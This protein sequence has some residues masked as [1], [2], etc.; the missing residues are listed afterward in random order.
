M[1]GYGAV[2]KDWRARPWQL[3]VA[4]SE[5]H[6]EHRLFDTQSKASILAFHYQS[7]NAISTWRFQIEW[8]LSFSIS[9][10]SP[11]FSYDDESKQDTTELPAGAY[12]LHI[13]CQGLRSASR[14][15]LTVT[16]YLVIWKRYHIELL[17]LEHTW[18][19]LHWL[20]LLFSIVGTWD[21][22]E[23]WASIKVS[24][25]LPPYYFK[26]HT[27]WWD[28]K[29][30]RWSNSPSVALLP[31]F[32]APCTGTWDIL[33]CPLTMGSLRRSWLLQFA[34]SEV[35]LQHCTF[36]R[37]FAN[38][39]LLRLL[40][41]KE[42]EQCHRVCHAWWRNECTE[43]RG[44]AKLYEWMRTLQNTLTY[45]YH[46][47]SSTPV[48]L[49]IVS[50]TVHRLQYAFDYLWMWVWTSRSKTIQNHLWDEVAFHP[51]LA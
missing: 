26:Q 1:S 19:D 10:L 6:Q 21:W 34:L 25:S 29:Q 32:L 38:I 39:F 42:P 5:L 35:I 23:H 17:C 31:F 15:K 46:L 24:Q 3:Q 7:I 43:T 2:L 44:M 20:L 50:K 51:C 45:L 33:R 30:R 22:F 12:C 14:W 4:S 48:W 36:V 8:V 41:E 9:S 16:A 11:N 13:V 18:W 40:V 49:L 28:I 37:V 27:P 47:E